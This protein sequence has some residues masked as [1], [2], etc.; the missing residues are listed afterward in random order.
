MDKLILK[1]GDIFSTKNPMALG[2]LI[3][4]GEALPWRDGHKSEYG[5]SGIIT[6]ELGNTVEE[7]W[8]LCANNLSSYEGDKII[9]GRWKNMTL[10]S[11]NDGMTVACADLYQPYP[12][13][14]LG[15][16]L[17]PRVAKIISTGKWAVCSERTFQFLFAAG[18]KGTDKIKTWQDN[19]PQA[20]ADL[21]HAGGEFELIYEGI[22]SKE[23]IGR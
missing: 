16:M 11:W 17:F 6:D 20:L 10:D 14:R 4:L 13:W 9:I 2:R 3:G 5:H 7:L 22:W 12:F 23:L 8:T 19:D 18:W 21:I 15:L 1:P